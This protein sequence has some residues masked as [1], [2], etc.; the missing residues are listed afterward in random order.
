MLLSIGSSQ[1]KVFIVWSRRTVA[2]R[3]FISEVT[4]VGMGVEG[5]H[6]GGEGNHLKSFHGGCLAV[7]VDDFVPIACQEASCVWIE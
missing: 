1:W 7:K 5:F 2:N 4:M 3:P 6:G